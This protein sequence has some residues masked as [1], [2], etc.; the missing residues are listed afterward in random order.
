MG[1]IESGSFISWLRGQDLR[2]DSVG[3][4]AKAVKADPRSR[5]LTTPEDLSKRLNQDEVEWE[6]HDALEC[7][8]SEWRAEAA[9]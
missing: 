7:A 2:E 6:L 1:R 9:L 5:L 3:D 4:L 8:E